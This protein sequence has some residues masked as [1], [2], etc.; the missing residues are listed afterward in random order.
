MLQKVTSS[1]SKNE[2]GY[3][4][5]LTESTKPD[6]GR[7]KF[8]SGP[9]LASTFSVIPLEEICASFLADRIYKFVEMILSHSPISVIVKF[10]VYF[11]QIHMHTEG[12]TNEQKNIL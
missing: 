12:F 8:S 2:Y 10:D 11:L 7:K 4:I 6:H 5:L 3:Y 9:H 1:S